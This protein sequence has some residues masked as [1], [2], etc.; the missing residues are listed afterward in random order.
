MAARTV[1]E[2]DIQALIEDLK[3]VAH[4]LWWSWNPEAQD[5]FHELSPF[6]WE[7]YEPQRG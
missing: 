7:R 5:I 3:G 1:P 4:N 6:F 2:K